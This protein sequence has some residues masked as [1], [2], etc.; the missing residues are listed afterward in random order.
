[1]SINRGMTTQ[2]TIY[3]Y[4]W[5]YYTVVKKDELNLCVGTWTDLQIIVEKKRQAV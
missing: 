2:T 1:M 3:L 5:E 4:L